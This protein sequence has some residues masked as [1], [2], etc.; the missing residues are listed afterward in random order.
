LAFCIVLIAGRP[1]DQIVVGERGAKS[2]LLSGWT[3]ENVDVERSTAD[4]IGT[5]RD[6]PTREDAD[7]PS[8]ANGAILLAG[9]ATLVIAIMVFWRYRWVGRQ[10]QP[11]AQ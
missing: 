4:A 1:L 2:Y 9:W 8:R 5:R 11:E 7:R 3:A 10:H 6:R